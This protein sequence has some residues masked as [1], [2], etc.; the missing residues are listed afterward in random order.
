MKGLI[1]SGGFTIVEVSIVLAITGVIM[2]ATLPFISSKQDDT[3]F[4]IGINQITSNITSSINNISTGNLSGNY[5]CTYASGITSG[6]VSISSG[7]NTNKGACEYVGEAIYF[8]QT[9][10]MV[11]PIITSSSSENLSNSHLCPILATGAPCSSVDGTTTFKYPNN[12]VLSK[13]DTNTLSSSNGGLF[14]YI[15]INSVQQN[16]GLSVDSLNVSSSAQN[17]SSNLYYLT[18][19]ISNFSGSYNIPLDLCFYN[20]STNQNR[21]ITLS[22]NNSPTEISLGSIGSGSC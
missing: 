16:G 6:I 22:S 8:M 11:I 12:L 2:I 5:N 19:N 1:S 4:T 17:N 18:Q 20:Q 9:S 10:Y 3:E 14:A 7:S 21:T 13:Y 15:S